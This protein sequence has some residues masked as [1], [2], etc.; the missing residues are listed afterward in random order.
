M[1]EHHGKDGCPRTSLIAARADAW[2]DAN[3]TAW[4]FMVDFAEQRVEAGICFGMQEIFERLRRAKPLDSVGDDFGL[5]NSFEP[6][7]ARRLV[8]EVPATKSYI[9]LRRSRFDDWFSDGDR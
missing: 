6:Y 2:V 3:S 8:R 4:S 7:L 5:N 1:S 9:T